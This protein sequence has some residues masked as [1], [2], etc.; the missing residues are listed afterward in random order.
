M[1]YRL[2]EVLKALL[3][4]GLTL[5]L[6]KCRF[7]MRIIEYLGFQIGRGHIWPGERKISAIADMPR[8]TNQTEVRRFLG[9]V[10][11]FRRFV[12]N[13]AVITSPISRLL[14]NDVQFQWEVIQDEAF[15]DIK[16]KLSCGPALKAYNA[17]AA[18]TELHTDA[19]SKGIA[20]MLLQSDREGDPLALVYAVSRTTSQVEEKYHSS[21]LELMA[22]SWSTQR[23]RPFLIGIPFTIVTDCQ[24]LI[25]INTWKTQSSQIARWACELSEFDFTIKHRPGKQ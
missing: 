10:S 24:C 13:F 16:K 19:C 8:P 1:I 22:I 12:P 20:G 11:F 14:R 18:N 7:G 9:L 2:E 17:T 4:A 21:R 25:N 23:L 15:E 6:Q 3:A 5:N